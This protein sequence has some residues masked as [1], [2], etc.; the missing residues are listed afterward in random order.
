MKRLAILGS[1]GSV[2]ASTLDV[3]ARHASRFEVVALAAGKNDAVLLAQCIAHR[4]RF[5]VLADA[6]A[7]ERLRRALAQRGLPTEVSSGPEALERIV[8]LAEVDA[9]M[10]SIV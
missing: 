9:V 5:A 7:A 1:T 2:G 4:P 3:V 10:A 8:A 6:D